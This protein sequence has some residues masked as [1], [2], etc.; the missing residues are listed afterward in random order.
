MTKW[1]LNKLLRDNWIAGYSYYGSYVNE[2]TINYVSKY[3]TKDDLDNKD[4]TGK[5]LVSPGLGKNYVNRMKQ[6]HLWKNEK[7]NVEYQFRN[8]QVT[9]LPKYYKQ[10]LFTEDERERLWIYKMEEGYK[11]VMGEKIRVTNEEEEK[12][13]NNICDFYRERNKRV[14]FDDLQEWN[15]KKFYNKVQNREKY[16]KKHVKV[17]WDLYKKDYKQ[18][19]KEIWNIEK[20]QELDKKT[21]S[22]KKWSEINEYKNI[23]KNWKRYQWDEPP[24]RF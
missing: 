3:L 23:E 14:H 16:T 7:T 11:Y 24:M 13:Y 10:K 5:I 17:K 1:Q 22:V 8:G 21:L 2:K 12:D 20:I 4:F 9:M 19:E 6:K 15:I 18:K